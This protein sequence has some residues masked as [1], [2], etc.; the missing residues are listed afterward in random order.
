MDSDIPNGSVS[1][2]SDSDGEP[3]WP[4]LVVEVPSPLEDEIAGGM[5]GLIL[6]AEHR[7]LA[8]GRS[9]VRLF[10]RAPGRVEAALEAAH[11][12]LRRLGLD[13]ERCSLRLV[14]VADEPWVQRYQAAL[15]PMRLG[16]RFLILPGERQATASGR[17]PIRLAP[18]RAFGTGEHATTRLCAE[19]LERRVR[20]GSR[21]LDLGCG[22]GILSIVALHC[23]AAELLAL[24]HDR[25]A[26]DVAAEVLAVNGLSGRVVLRLGSIQDAGSR[27][28]SGIVANI[29]APFFLEQSAAIVS[30]LE[31]EGSLVASGFVHE[32]ADEI[33]EA[34]ARVGL[35]EVERRSSG[36]W[37]V[38]VG[39]RERSGGAS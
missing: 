9:S 31:P 34:L 21:W 32:Q 20:V 26:V 19:Q 16:R 10:L 29:H 24:D 18:G 12:L 8:P 13:A 25:E 27:P 5:A 6:G 30:A 17:Q 11:R 36:P 28:W 7:A 3:D 37:V 33:A 1:G 14:H 35:H 22:T 23:G 15:R 4:A 39:V 38:W 2:P